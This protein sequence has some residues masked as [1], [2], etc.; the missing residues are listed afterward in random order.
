MIEEKDRDIVQLLNFAKGRKSRKQIVRT[1]FPVKAKTPEEI[2]EEDEKLALE[3]KRGSLG[4][5]QQQKIL[6]ERKMMEAQ[7][8]DKT[9]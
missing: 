7:N 3:Y 6:K 4:W 9:S 8:A 5:L 2:L 1:A